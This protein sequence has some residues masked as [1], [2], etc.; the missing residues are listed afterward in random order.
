MEKTEKIEKPYKYVWR[1]PQHDPK[2]QTYDTEIAIKEAFPEAC[3]PGKH[4]W[5]STFAFATDD[6]RKCKVRR[7]MV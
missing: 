3:E 4:E 6:C 5:T 7:R 1:T 2:Q